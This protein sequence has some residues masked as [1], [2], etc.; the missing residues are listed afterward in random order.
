M[1]RVSFTALAIVAACV[2]DDR[3]E[4]DA[5]FRK[6]GCGAQLQLANPPVHQKCYFW[7]VWRPLPPDLPDHDVPA[8]GIG[9]LCLDDDRLRC[10]WDQPECQWGSTQLEGGCVSDGPGTGGVCTKPP[11]G[12]TIEVIIDLPVGSTLCDP[13]NRPDTEGARFQACAAVKPP[14]MQLA[15]G[16]V[17]EQVVERDVQCCVPKVAGTGGESSSSSGGL[18]PID[19]P[20][21]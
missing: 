12:P 11:Y 10:T 6:D 7:P 20:G 13:P 1:A 14:D 5:A 8:A 16:S 19:L 2:V 17:P 9:V 21:G 18:E 4:D 3:V 15:C